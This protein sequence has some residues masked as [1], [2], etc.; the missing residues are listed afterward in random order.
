MASKSNMPLTY[1]SNR[2]FFR[3]QL[4]AM[5]RYLGLRTYGADPILR[6]RIRSKLTSITNDD[7]LIMWEGGVDSLQDDEVLKA[8]Q[9]RGIRTIGVSKRK[10]RRQLGDW[11]EM[12]Q[13]REVPP[14]LMILSRA[15]FYTEVPENALK[16][17]LS[18]LPVDV[19]TDLKIAT[20]KDL[21]SA[22]RL[23][24]LKRQERLIAAEEAQHG[25]PKDRK[26]K[27]EAV[28]ETEPKPDVAP[29]TV[30]PIDLEVR[31]DNLKGAVEEGQKAIDEKI[32]PEMVPTSSARTVE[33]ETDNRRALLG[34][35]DVLETLES[36]DPVASERLDLENLKA[37][38]L[39]LEA[40]ITDDG[41]K[42]DS[43]V[44]RLKATMSKLEREFEKTQNKVGLKMKLL[45]TDKDG[46]IHIDEVLQAATLIAGAN[47]EDVIKQVLE[48]LDENND[49][50]FRKEDIKRLRR[51]IKQELGDSID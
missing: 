49:G 23:E 18:S 20:D 4:V 32:V 5:C 27:A 2:N 51:E 11:L 25:E 28:L 3:P 29:E 10:L 48:R 14:T 22:E 40:R 24:E 46:V 19:L 36:D 33:T 50:V 31:M 42:G 26:E 16:E 15:F 35:A 9:D 39:N 17:T 12:S 6:Y 43:Q 30:D 41:E 13:N 8:C 47:N 7:I 34:I 21:T 45:D 37:E 44:R 38:L 1:H